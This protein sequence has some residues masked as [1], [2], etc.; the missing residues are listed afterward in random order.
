MWWII[1]WKSF[2]KFSAR[3]KVRS[4]KAH[5]FRTKFFVNLRIDCFGKILKKK[6][7]QVLLYIK[8]LNRLILP[9][10]CAEKDRKNPAIEFSFNFQ[11]WILWVWDWLFF[12][13]LK[14]ILEWVLLF[15]PK[16]K[17]KIVVFVQRIIVESRI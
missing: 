17:L 10:F 15:V 4:A 1:S 2:R 14:C 6:I 11:H 8:E 7:V 3:C 5:C 9:T 13:T 16:D 12:C